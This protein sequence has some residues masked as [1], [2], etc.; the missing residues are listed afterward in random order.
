MDVLSG[1]LVFKKLRDQKKEKEGFE[2]ESDSMP[3]IV[4]FI[5]VGVVCLLVIVGC[6][7]AYLSWTSNTVC[8][9]NPLFKTI[10]AIFAFMFGTNYLCIYVVNRLDAII[11]L[12]KTGGR[13]K[14]PNIQYNNVNFLKKESNA[15]FSQNKSINSS[16]VQNGT[17][18][19]NRVITRNVPNSYKNA[20]FRM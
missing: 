20:G 17:S 6:L 15:S 9:W 12:K 5:W 14:I 18:N 3:P 19:A 2:T 8:G 16:L 4:L 7:S 11:L 1:F 13:Y 10:Y